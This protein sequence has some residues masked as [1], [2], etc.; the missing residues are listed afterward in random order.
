MRPTVPGHPPIESDRIYL[1]LLNSSTSFCPYNHRLLQNTLASNKMRLTLLGLGLCAAASAIPLTDPSSTND[2][3][4]EVDEAATLALREEAW[5][6]E[7]EHSHEGG[8]PA[9]GILAERDL[10]I[11]GVVSGIVNPVVSKISD[12]DPSLGSTVGG[13]LKTI[14]GLVSKIRDQLDN[15]LGGLGGG[16]LS[17]SKLTGLVNKFRS[18]TSQVE[19]LI[20]SVL[21]Q[22]SPQLGSKARQ[23]LNKLDSQITSIESQLGGGL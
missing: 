4:Q 10:P 16:Q 7:P 22:L 12:I 14:N 18:Y 1:S 19:T 6:W 5:D 11:L 3:S 13:L 2:L 9:S 17:A 8:L 20:E 15:S 21:D 23:L